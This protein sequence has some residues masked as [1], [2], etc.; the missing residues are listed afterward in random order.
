[1]CEGGGSGGEEVCRGQRVLFLR[2]PEGV[3]SGGMSTTEEDLSNGG[4]GGVW[5]TGGVRPR[6]ILFGVGGCGV[7]P[8]ERRASEGENDRQRIY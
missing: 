6:M 3:G 1:M 8:R 7:E 2:S 4:R 5:S